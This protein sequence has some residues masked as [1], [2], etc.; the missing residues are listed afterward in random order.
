MKIDKNK[1]LTLKKVFIKH[2][3]IDL[4]DF[5]YVALANFIVPKKSICQNMF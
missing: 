5:Q 4:I 3:E 1:N 2:D